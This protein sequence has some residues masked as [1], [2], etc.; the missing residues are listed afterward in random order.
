MVAT[1]AARR[2][3]AALHSEMPMWSNLPSLT[4]VFRVSM[5]DSI[6]TSWS[7]RADS[8]KSNFFLPRKAALM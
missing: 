6:G 3:V 8:N 1:L 4:S 5:A 7:I 2:R